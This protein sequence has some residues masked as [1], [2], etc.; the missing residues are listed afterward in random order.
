MNDAVARFAR[1]YMPGFDCRLATFRNTLAFH[2]HALSNGMVLGLSGTLCFV[3]SDGVADRLRRPTLAGLSDQGLEGLAT[4]LG[5]YLYRGKLDVGD[6]FE[7]AVGAYLADDLP[8]SVA[9]Y[10]PGLRARMSGQ[11]LPPRAATDVG[12]HYVTLTAHDAR[13]HTFTLFETDSSRPFTLPCAELHA[14]WFRDRLDPRPRR[15]PLQPCDGYWYTFRA[16]RQIR[17][18]LAAGARQALRRVAHH[19]HDG[20]SERVG[21]RALERFSADVRTW[22]ERWE[23][24][25]DIDGALLLLRVLEG[26]LTGGGF[27]RKLYA[28]FLAEAAEL[29]GAPALRTLGAQFRGTADG[30]KAFVAELGAARRRDTPDGVRAG[31]R[32]AVLRHADALIERERRQMDALAAWCDAEAA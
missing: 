1:N 21:A 11:T 24:G 32:E 5:C 30:W 3:Y 10:R 9:L 20:Y 28:C 15:D 26:P 14:L 17:P 18:L 31:L 8:L 13:A 19:F 29:L 22:P 12:F 6:D 2:G 27:G 23:P 16:P 4:A 7:A 25:G